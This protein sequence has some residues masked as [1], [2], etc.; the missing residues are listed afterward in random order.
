[1]CEGG[2]KG[3]GGRAMGQGSDEERECRKNGWNETRA[4]EHY[5]FR[6]E[7]VCVCVCKRETVVIIRECT[8]YRLLEW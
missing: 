5:S 6:E 3:R 2:G 4:R 8:V 1:M 7:K